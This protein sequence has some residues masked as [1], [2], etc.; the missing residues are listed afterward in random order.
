[1]PKFEVVSEYKPSGEPHKSHAFAG[2][3]DLT[4]MCR[5]SPSISR[6][7]L[8]QNAWRRWRGGGA[9]PRWLIA[10]VYHKECGE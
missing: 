1:M 9:L 4:Q 6:F 7:C 10:G 2:P 3:R 5:Q 8:R